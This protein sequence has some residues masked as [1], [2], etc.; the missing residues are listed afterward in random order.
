MSRSP[1]IRSL[2][3]V[4]PAVEVRQVPLGQRHRVRLVAGD[5]T[6]D[7]VAALH[8]DGPDV[9]RPVFAESAALDHRRTTHADVG[10]GRRDDHITGPGQRGVTGEATPGHDR[11]QRHLAAQRTKRAERH[12]VEAGDVGHVGVAGPAAAAFGEQHHRQLPAGGQIEDA[13]GLGMVAHALRAGQ[14]GV[15]VRQHSRLD[16]ADFR[17]PGDQA[18]GR[19]VGDQILLRTPAALRCDRQRAVFD[20]T[21]RVHQIGDVLSGGTPILFVPLGNRRLSSFV[22][23]E[24]VPTTDVVEVFARPVQINVCRIV[25]RRALA[26]A[27]EDHQRVPGPDDLPGRDQRP[28]SAHRVRGSQHVLHLHRFEH[29]QLRA[30]SELG[31]FR[32]DLDHGA[33]QLRA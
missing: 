26:G 7:A 12:Q 20:E 25:C 16:S 30:R 10:V 24:Q 27:D 9:L 6:D 13:I 8:I 4:E 28:D 18:I 5:Q 11:H 15:V 23:G 2:P 19:G 17:H 31:A 33:G 22:E 32:R 29:H 21:P 14:D 1:R 3:L